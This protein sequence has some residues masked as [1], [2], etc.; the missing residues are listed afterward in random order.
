M[1]EGGKKGWRA[2][3]SVLIRFLQ[4]MVTALGTHWHP[5]HFCCVSCGEPFGDEGE[6]V[7]PAL[8]DTHLLNIRPL[9]L[10]SSLLGP[11]TS[12][13]PMLS[14]TWLRPIPSHWATSLYPS[15][16]LYRSL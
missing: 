5:E 1:G 9:S 4:K 8:K 10:W 14:H 3:R 2:P 6:N 13:G 12:P 7:A 16:P 11:P 15:L